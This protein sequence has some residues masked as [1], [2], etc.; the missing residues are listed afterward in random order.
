MLPLL[1]PLLLWAR[2]CAANSTE[3][4]LARRAAM[5]DAVYGAGP[6]VLPTRSEPD[7][8]ISWPEEPGLQGH[9]WNISN[10]LFPINS[11]VFYKP[12]RPGARAKSAV[13]YHHGHGN[14]VCPTKAG[15]APIDAA[16]CRPGCRAGPHAVTYDEVRLQ[17]LYG[18]F[19]W[20]D[21]N[22]VT[23]FFHALGHDIFILSMPLKGVNLG[24]GSNASHLETSH[25]WFLQWERRGDAALRYF[26]EPVYLTVNW[27][28]RHGYE[29]IIM[30]G[31]SGGGWTTTAASAL[32]PRIDASFPIAGSIPCALRNPESWVAGQ[33]WTGNSDEDFEQ[34]CR[35]NATDPHPDRTGPECG[36]QGAPC[37]DAQPGRALYAA[38]NYTCQYLLAGLEPNRFQVQVLHEYDTCCFSPHGRHDKMLEYEA[39]IRAELM[40]DGRAS[41]GHGWFTTTADNHSKHEIAAQD[42]TI[43]ANA[44]RLSPAPGAAAWEQLPCDIMHQPLPANCAPNVEPGMPPGWPGAC[45]NHPGNLPCCPGINSCCKAKGSCPNSTAHVRTSPSVAGYHEAEEANAQQ[46]AAPP[47]SVAACAEYALPDGARARVEPGGGEDTVRVR[48]VP[49]GASSFRS[50][51]PS[52]LLPGSSAAGTCQ[53][54]KLGEWFVSS[55]AR[56][57][58]GSDGSVSVQRVS[59][60]QQLFKSTPIAWSATTIAGIPL[61]TAALDLVTPPDPVFGLGQHHDPTSRQYQLAP[62]NG[63]TTI[64]LMHWPAA[65]ASLLIN[66]PSSGTLQTKPRGVSWRSDACLQLDLWVATT[67]SGATPVQRWPELLRKYVAATGQPAALPEWATGFIQSKDR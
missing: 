18:G 16:K 27:A 67:S 12:I 6:G 59:D 33:N 56:A 8:V 31:L 38:C 11:T 62:S 43:V 25:W 13:L 24:P 28:K 2:G 47:D 32:D 54:M 22:N 4:W 5:I 50:D 10:G 53:T 42:R 41:R 52:A 44:L 45:I 57:T 61:H 23:R 64:P 30:A 63:E 17:A 21:R 46:R 14:C 58:I 15:D 40:T 48:V 49:P 36:R 20:W 29:K 55:N 3:S 66:V 26:L 39:N 9:V 19:S 60:S 37:P 34:S 65:G 1:L 35:P 51:L 7:A